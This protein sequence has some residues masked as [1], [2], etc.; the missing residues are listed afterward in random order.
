[1]G[2]YP[3][4]T[5]MSDQ[6]KIKISVFGLLNDMTYHTA[7][8]CA[9]DLVSKNPDIYSSSEIT[10]MLEFE[11]DLFIEA[12]CK[13][14]GGEMWVFKDKAVAF[15]NS[16]LIGGPEDFLDWAEKEHNYENFR[17]LPLYHTLAEEAYKGYLNSTN[18]DFVYMHISIGEKPVG[19]LVFELFT[20][21]V[22]KTC[23]NFRAL[24]TGE[25]GESEHTEYRLHY[26]KSIFHRIV[27][28]GW[29]QGGDIWMKKR[30][31]WGV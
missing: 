25:K 14:L 23:E 3:R 1:M 10:G 19:R 31:W 12:K 9:G 21:I 4:T 2:K 30:R 28:N 20:D 15:V 16:Q 29:I 5:N 27:K 6:E 22:P 13:E 7:K 11:W 17:P 26:L 24:C 8:C 18:H